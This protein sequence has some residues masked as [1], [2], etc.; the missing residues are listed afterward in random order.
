MVGTLVHVIFTVLMV[1]GLIA[2][3]KLKNHRQPNRRRENT[4]IS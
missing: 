2:T 1:M 4:T 3:M